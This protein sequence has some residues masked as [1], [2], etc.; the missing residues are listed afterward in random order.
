MQKRFSLQIGQV[1]KR[2]EIV[3]FLGRRPPKSD[4]EGSKPWKGTCTKRNTSLETYSVRIGPELPP[5][6]VH[7][8]DE[9]TDKKLF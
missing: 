7:R 2:V 3:V 9:E 1:Q 8:R 4:F 5:V 6:G